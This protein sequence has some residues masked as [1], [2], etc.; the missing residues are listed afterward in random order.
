MAGF[1][2]VLDFSMKKNSVSSRLSQQV[3]V[4]IS[5]G[6][7]NPGDI[8][9]ISPGVGHYGSYIDPSQCY[10]SFQIKN[11]DAT[12]ALVLD[13]SAYSAFDRIIVQS[14]G[15]T[16]SDLQQFP[17]WAQ[18]MLDSQLS[19]GKSG[20][21]STFAGTK[22]DGSLNNV[23]A[24][25][26]IAASGS[27]FVSMPLIGTCIDQTAGDKLIPAGALSDLQL[28]FYVS[29]VNNLGVTSSASANWSLA[30]ITLTVGY[31]TLDA[32]AQKMIDDVQGGE[33]KWSVELWKGFNYGLAANST[34]DSVI[35]PWKGS[36]LK[37]VAAIQ[38][39]AG[40]FNNPAALTNTSR[41][42]S[43][44]TATSGANTSWFVA[45]GSDNYPSIPI[46][47]TT[48]FAVE[49]L[50]MWHGLGVPSALQTSFDSS[51]WTAQDSAVATTCGSFV[52]G[53]N[54]EAYSGK[55]GTI[56]SGVAVLGGTTL[57]LQQGYVSTG[58]GN[59]ANA[60][61]TQTTYCGYD[62]VITVKEGIMSV[63]F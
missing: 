57:V 18:L 23:R 31:V 34:A 30:G 26:T 41:L 50:K 15:S 6:S 51:T 38:R 58:I 4:P 27:L 24:G 8:V 53:L 52:A 5:G 12:N 3:Y 49:Y 11:A 33:Y 60:P 32:S 46:R 13:G 29:A 56:H 7:A 1:P 47:N 42:C 28:M 10:I 40:N 25:A 20:F 22:T 35:V 14:S 17:A 19:T 59:G 45:V 61:V 16:I 54:L 9:T 2:S 48:Q 37:S 44:A 21:M 55:T 36:S 43:Y 63:A 39:L 62:A